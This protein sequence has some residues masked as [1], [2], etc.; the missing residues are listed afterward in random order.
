MKKQ[1][2]LNFIIPLVVYPFNIMVSI[3]ES[4]ESLYKK[5]ISRGVNI[6]LEELRH[7]KTARGRTI[8]FEGNQTLIRMYENNKTPEWRGNLAHEIF[9]SV[10]F[11][12][13]R[14]GAKLTYESCEPYAYLT[15]YITKEIYKRV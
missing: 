3:A 14:V 11:I 13:S 12:L 1:K 7:S 15:D 2:A 5:L 10:D 4:D 9:H 6:S 8:M